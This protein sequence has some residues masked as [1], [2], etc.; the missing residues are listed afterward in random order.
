MVQGY[1]HIHFYVPSN[2]S[3]A[4]MQ[5]TWLIFIEQIDGK[6]NLTQLYKCKWK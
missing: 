6:C 5:D 3:K 2:K 1:C 4:A